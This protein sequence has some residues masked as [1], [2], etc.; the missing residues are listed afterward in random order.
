M[1]RKGSGEMH[2]KT[3]QGEKLAGKAAAAPE[4]RAV[5]ERKSL[6]LPLHAFAYPAL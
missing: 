2:I 1:G 6:L 4:S 5:A 3:P